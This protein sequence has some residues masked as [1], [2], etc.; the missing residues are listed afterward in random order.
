MRPSLHQRQPADFQHIVCAYDFPD[1]CNR[2]KGDR[3]ND[4]IA[5]ELASYERRLEDMGFH[6]KS[7]GAY[8]RK[9]REFLGAN[10]HVLDAGEADAAAAIND[11][12]GAGVA[13]DDHTRDASLRK[14]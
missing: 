4:P 7:V 10:P 6:P 1:G 13:Y 11:F 5:R 2:E 8:S 3:M 14:W 12:M 9:L